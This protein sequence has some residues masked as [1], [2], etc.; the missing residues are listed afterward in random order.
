MRKV[1]KVVPAQPSQ[2]G[3][4]VKINRSIGSGYLP[5]LDP[6]L[7]L[8]EIRSDDAA[9]YIGGFPP[10]PHR[11]FETVTYM[12]E[13]KMRHRDSCGNE[14]VI[15]TGGLQWM[16]AGKGILHSEM[17]EQTEGRLWGFQIWVNL[18][19]T[20][21]MR[22][23]RYQEFTSAQIPEL[24]L[25]EKSVVRVL[26]GEVGGVIGVAKD[27][28]T[29][30]FLL[31]LRL[32]GDDFQLELP[33][34]HSALLYVYK[35]EFTIEGVTIKAGNLAILSVG[36]LIKCTGIDNASGNGALLLAAAKLEEPI[37]RY[38]PFVMNT[39]AELQ[40]AFNDFQQGAFGRM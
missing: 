1:A 13:G 6:F 16:T 30:P 10:H 2:D 11:G 18:K 37:E 33:E 7:L 27:I 31:D 20:E 5:Q 39:R 38:G 15:E 17:P 4:G 21:K 19:S 12:L 3:D 40:Q 24:Q 35:G 34:L 9:D 22:E 32:N 23:P 36:N 28:A 25:S 8:D 14:G 26:A 29:N